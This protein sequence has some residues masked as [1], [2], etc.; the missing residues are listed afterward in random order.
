MCRFEVHPPGSGVQYATS[1]VVVLEN[2]WKLMQKE[3]TNHGVQ[4]L[5]DAYRTSR[6]RKRFF[7]NIRSMICPHHHLLPSIT[8]AWHSKSDRQSSTHTFSPS[9]MYP[10]FSSL[11]VKIAARKSHL[12][13]SSVRITSADTET[14]IKS[15]TLPRKLLQVPPRNTVRWNLALPVNIMDAP[16][17]LKSS[18][19]EHN[20]L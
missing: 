6:R 11:T 13:I 12:I 1:L 14:M 17:L 19:E 9:P 5:P 15:F 4:L 2:N 10:I 3:V 7:T 20:S 8:S 16:H 18:Y